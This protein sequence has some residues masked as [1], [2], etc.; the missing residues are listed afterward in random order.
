VLLVVSPQGEWLNG[1]VI[2]ANGGIAAWE[3][4]LHLPP[5]LEI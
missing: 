2:R 5:H 4:K 1:Q 3:A